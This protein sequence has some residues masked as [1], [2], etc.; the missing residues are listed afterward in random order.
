MSLKKWFSE[1]VPIDP[2]IFKAFSSEPVP[3]HLRHW[4]WCLGGTPAYLFIVQIITGILLSI[5]YIP[6]IDH[7]YESV[8]NISENVNYGWY[9]RSVHKWSANFMIV[10]VIL[11]MLRIFF[12]GSYRKPREVNWM[13]GV[14]LFVITLLIGFSGY[15]LIF[16][17][18]SY[19]GLTVAGNLL[20][21]VPLVGKYL[22]AF[23]KDGDSISQFTL[24]RMFIFHAAI[25][26]MLLVGFIFLHVTL[27]HLQGI[28][29][30]YFDEKEKKK[31]F[32]FI[33]NHL[34]T[35][36]ILAVIL[37][38]LVSFMAIVFPAGLEEK[39]NPLVTPPHIKPEW[40]FYFTFRILKITSIT[41][42]VLIM[43]AA[44]FILF[45][46]PL[47]D[48]KLREKK[49]SEMSIVVGIGAV[50]LLCAL[51]LW[52]AIALFTGH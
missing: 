10:S 2:E 30:F 11:H 42:A 28:T 13:V 20:D 19:W 1:R 18:L 9:I 32:P 8:Q 17:Q 31:T 14:F 24:S 34:M 51:T 48:A 41:A 21:A 40:Y 46:W 12:T 16:E 27:I 15:S 52:E 49:N 25:L 33:P 44:F 22:A 47:I 39:A 36:I 35:E 23:I 3:D 5:Y 7:A 4:W 29:T 6:A 50:F 26:P 37:M 38:I 45:L 43:G